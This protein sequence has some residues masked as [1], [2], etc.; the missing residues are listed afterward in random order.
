MTWAG[1][2]VSAKLG[3][4][5]QVAEHDRGLA[6]HAAEAQAVGAASTSSTTDSGTKRANASR[7]W[8]R[9]KATVMPWMAPVSSSA[10]TPAMSA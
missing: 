4:A 10:A 3:E 7:V 1:W 2:S 8:A 9:S 6:L 5:A